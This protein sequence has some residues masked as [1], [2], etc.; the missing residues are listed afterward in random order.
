MADLGQE[1]DLTA[2]WTEISV[3]LTLE[4]GKDYLVDVDGVL[5]GVLCFWAVT[6]TVGDA[7]LVS[8][9]PFLPFRDFDGQINSRSFTKNAGQFL[10]LKVSK[11]TGTLKI[12]PAGS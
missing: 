8:G 12:S 7:P 5:N 11:G 2:V 10:W 1:L 9:H 6:D 4:D 3:P